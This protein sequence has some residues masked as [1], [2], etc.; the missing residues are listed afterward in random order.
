MA[1][2][3]GTALRNSMVT[4]VYNFKILYFAS[5]LLLL[6]LSSSSSSSA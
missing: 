4:N 6:L 2:L 5:N 3:I 1:S